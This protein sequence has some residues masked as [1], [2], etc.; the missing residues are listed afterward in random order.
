M[1]IFNPLEIVLFKQKEKMKIKST[2]FATLLM[3]ALSGYCGSTPCED[4]VDVLCENCGEDSNICTTY[5]ETEDIECTST[6]EKT[7]KK[8]EDIKKGDAA[9]K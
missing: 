7:Y 5:R 2:L 6:V 8:L 1:G 3:A 4:S 9:C